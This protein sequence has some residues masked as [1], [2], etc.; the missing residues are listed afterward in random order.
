V[1]K[2]SGTQ[3]RLRP[4]KLGFSLIF[5]NQDRTTFLAYLDGQLAR[6]IILR[7]N[8]KQFAFIED[9]IVDLGFRR[10]GV[11]QRLITQAKQWAR[12]QE[13]DGLMLET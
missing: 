6:Q 1:I 10:C 5:G 7:K 3:K 12:E 9:I 8:W 11:G 2:I 13:L 4:E